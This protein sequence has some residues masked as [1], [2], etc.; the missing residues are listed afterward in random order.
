MN[1]YKGFARGLSPEFMHE[2]LNGR[3]AVL[4]QGSID[5]GLDLQIRE[6]YINLYTSGRSVLELAEKGR[7]G[8]CAKI[9][10]KFLTDTA[11]PPARAVQGEY[12][13][14]AADDGFVRAYL[15]YADKIISNALATAATEA[16][17]EE[18]MIR[19]SYVEGSPI[20]F[21]DRQIQTHG[22]RKRLDLIGISPSAHT[23]VLTEIKQGLDNRIQELMEQVREYHDVLAP[24]GHLRADIACSYATVVAQKQMLGAMPKGVDFPPHPPKAECLLLLY[25][26]N[27][28]SRLLGRLRDSVRSYAL[29]PKLVCLRAG[30]YSLPPPHEWEQL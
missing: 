30:T 13:H 22:I 4:R 11:L 21:I 27:P 28:K 10:R 14:L 7:L 15:A 19:Q 29:R 3:F 17:I 2:L 25:D 24:D 9:H 1:Q 16:T 20:V 8:Y 12:H 5:R 26:Y 6:N 18:E 23:V